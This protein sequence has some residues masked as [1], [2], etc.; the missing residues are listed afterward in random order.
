MSKI[1]NGG[2]NPLRR[3]ARRASPLPNDPLEQARR[4]ASAARD[5]AR[6]ERRRLPDY[7]ADTEEITQNNVHVHVHQSGTNSQPEVDTTVEVGPVKLTGLPKWGI[8]AIGLVIAAITAAV[9][10]FLAK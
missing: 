8:A 2:S 3:S 9:S 10:R 1:Q 5:I 7:D 6:D 4:F